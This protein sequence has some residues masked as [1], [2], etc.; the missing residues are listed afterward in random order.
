MEMGDT[1]TERDS[2][3]EME[4][5]A[6][7]YYGASTQRAVLNFPI[8]DLRFPRRFIQALGLIKQ[9]AAEANR[10]LGLLDEGLATAIIQ[11]AQ[12]VTDGTLDDEFVL[13]IFQTGSGTSTNMNANEVI[14]NRAVEILGEARGSR[15]VHPNDHVNICQS[16]NDVIPAAMHLSA[17]LSIRQD[18]IP[19]LAKLQRALVGK[20]EEFMPIIKTGRTHLQDATPIRLG[21]EFQGYAGQIERAIKHLRHA[22][23]WLGELALGGTAV[24]TGINAHPAFARLVCAK[25][26]AATGYHIRETEN[27]FQ[28]QS[29]I[30][31]L[32]MTSGMLNTVAVALLKI[33]ND[34]RWLGS[35][36]RARARR[37]A[38][39]GSAAGEQHH[40]REG[41]SRHSRIGDPGLRA[42]DGQPPC[43]DHC[44]PVGILRVEYN[45]A[46]GGVQC[47]AADSTAEQSG[48]E[49]CRPVRERHSSYGTRPRH[50]RTRPNDCYGSGALGG[51]RPGCRDCQD[52]PRR[53]QD[54]P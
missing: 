53:K 4:V 28:A 17:L 22:E 47:L 40:A 38:A 30:D 19:A 36:P 2:M 52:C 23:D 39:A 29:A 42:G 21:Q 49:F 9:K 24:G 37:T 33:A 46:G 45:A 8:S 20:A 34:I 13:D 50:S 26:R 41:K 31:T 16:S 14:A 1:R 35:G 15:T 18:L 25:L 44:G 43:G 12:E 3:G 10:E 11:A 51:L 27:H 7:A 5:P 6:D 48:G 32:V 54:R